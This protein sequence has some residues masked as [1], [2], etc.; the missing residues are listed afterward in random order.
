MRYKDKNLMTPFT[1]ALVLILVLTMMS[2]S[3]SASGTSPQKIVVNGDE[4]K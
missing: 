2:S 3:V 4:L 1:K